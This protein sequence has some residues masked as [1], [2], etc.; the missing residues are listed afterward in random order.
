MQQEKT[1]G[2]SQERRLEMYTKRN[3]RTEKIQRGSYG[4]IKNCKRKKIITMA[5]LMIAAAIIFTIGLFLNKFSK[6]NIFTVVAVLL[7][8]PWA[9]VLTSYI[10]MFPYHT[11]SKEQYEKLKQLETEGLHIYSDLVITSEEKVMNLDFL[12][13]G[14]QKVYGVLG[15]ENQDL[16][17]INQYLKKGITNQTNG[18]DVK[19]VKEFK[20]FLPLVKGVSEACK[21]NRETEKEKA[22][23]EEKAE[24]YMISLIVQ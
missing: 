20:Q 24:A 5:V 9:K 23:E 10:V 12:V 22:A 16:T 3:N 1:A 6:A 7:V 15:K 21:K 8:L 19:M 14:N 11:P 4:Y 18:M 13:I 17:Y 2:K